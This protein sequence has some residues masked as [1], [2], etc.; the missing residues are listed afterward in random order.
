VVAADR[1][2]PLAPP[3]TWTLT[4]AYPEVAPMGTVVANP[5]GTATYTA[6]DP[7]PAR[8]PSI[9]PVDGIQATIAVDPPVVAV[10]L[11]GVQGG[12][13]SSNPVITDVTAGG[14]SLLGGDG[15]IAMGATTPLTVVT[16]VA[17]DDTWTFAWYATA[18]TID[19]YQSNPTELVGGD[20][21]GPGWIYV[22][23]RDGRGGAAV[24]AVPV[25]VR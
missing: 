20:A 5:D 6:P 10:K 23:V 11:V 13:A 7:V 16:D 19:H 17:P 2:G 1:G 3:T 24:R 15:V 21:P 18:G 4:E 9:P 12:V 14:A 22:V 8:P 25:T